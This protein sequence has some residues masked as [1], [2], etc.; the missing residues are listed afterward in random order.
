M[1]TS[2][3]QSKI[4]G[5][6]AGMFDLQPEDVSDSK[7]FTEMAKYDSMRALEF[8]SKLENE[9]NVMID[10]DQLV[11]MATVDSSTQV[12]EGLLRAK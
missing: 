8:L 3:I 5:I 2:E 12:I 9:F 6:I 10:P 11:N 4:K 1:Q 7:S